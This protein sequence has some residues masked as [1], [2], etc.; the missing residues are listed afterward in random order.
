MKVLLPRKRLLLRFLLHLLKGKGDN[1][2]YNRSLVKFADRS[3]IKFDER[4]FVKLV[5]ENNRP[6]ICWLA[7]ICL[8]ICLIVAVGGAT[9]LTQSGLS[10]VDWRPVTGI[11]PPLNQA[12]WQAAF[13]AYKQYPEYQKINRGMNLEEFKTIFYWEYAH[14]LLGRLVGL[15]F[16]VPFLYFLIRGQIAVRW[17][18]RLWVALGLG[19]LQGF[20]G[21]YMVQSGLVDVPRVS[22]YRLAAHLLLALGILIYLVHLMLDMSGTEVHGVGRRHRR[23]VWLAAGLL[24]VQLIFGVLTAGLKAGHGFNTWPLM[25]DQWLPDAALMM[26]PLLLNLLENGV[27]VQ[28]VHRWLGL[29]LLLAATALAWT[30]WRRRQLLALSALLLGLTL[31]QFALGIATLLLHVPVLLG[32]LHQIVA[33]LMVIAMTCL[34]YHAGHGGSQALYGE[35]LHGDDRQAHQQ[36]LQEQTP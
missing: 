14:R 28:F 18:P 23:L 3:L 10:M 1:S 24:G 5:N 7:L 20:M 19:A 15:L 16:L 9:R 34:V 35:A 11:V 21:W 12:D 13:D 31:I 8:M 25:H 36:A 29:A 30:A 4:L 17:Q 27:M 26:Q 22:H 2:S 6:L 32:S 33:T